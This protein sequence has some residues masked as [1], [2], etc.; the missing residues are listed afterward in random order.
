MDDRFDYCFEVFQ[1][2]AGKLLFDINEIGDWCSWGLDTKEP[3]IPIGQIKF[4]NS[5]DRNRD[6]VYLIFHI[7]NHMLYSDMLAKVV[8]LPFLLGK[9]II[10]NNFSELH[11][12]LDTQQNIPSL[13]KK[14][15]RDK[16]ITILLPQIYTGA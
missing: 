1:A 10:F 8:Q 2:N 16:S 5:I 11:I 6:H 13:I 15:L 4:S 7:Y 12:A 9:N 3:E 14:M